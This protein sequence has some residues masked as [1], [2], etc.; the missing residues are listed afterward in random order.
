VQ[1][2]H[3][4]HFALIPG[5]RYL[6]AANRDTNNIVTFQVDRESGKLHYTGNSIEVS[7]PVCVQPFY[8]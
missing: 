3:P 8:L 4:R 5:G 6:I 2:A 1:G 7:K